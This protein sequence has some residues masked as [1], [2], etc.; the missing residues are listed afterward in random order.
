M[1]LLEHK[2]KKVYLVASVIIQLC[3]YVGAWLVQ[4]FTAKK[5]G[6]LRWVNSVSNKWSKKADVEML[7]C[8]FAIFMAVAVM[9]LL[10][11][12]I[13]RVQR[14]SAAFEA[15]MTSAVLSTGAYIAFVVGGSRKLIASFYLLSPL[16]ALAALVTVIM[17]LAAVVKSE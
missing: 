5:M 10:F 16:L 13:D 14:R 6:M 17:F 4:R 9:L 2:M 7:F 12:A 1:V 15:L 8:L 3:C 11:W